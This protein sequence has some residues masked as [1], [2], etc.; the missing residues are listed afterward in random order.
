MLKKHGNQLLKRQAFSKFLCGKISAFTIYLGCSQPRLDKNLTKL[1]NRFNAQDIGYAYRPIH[2][3]ETPNNSFGYLLKLNFTHFLWRT[4]LISSVSPQPNCW[5]FFLGHVPCL[6]NLSSDTYNLQSVIE[7]WPK[8][9]QT[10][11]ADGSLIC[12][13]YFS[14]QF[15]FEHIF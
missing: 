13:L 4:Q 10:K 8:N 5:V 15:C 7:N 9:S 6:S 12:C 3:L 1:M 11:V 14:M 2:F